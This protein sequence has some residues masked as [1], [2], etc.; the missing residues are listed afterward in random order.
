MI[1]VNTGS[2]TGRG[3]GSPRG[4]DHEDEPPGGRGGRAPAAAA[5]HRRHHRHRLHRHGVHAQPRPGAGACCARRSRSDRT[6]T[7]VVEISPLGLVEMTRQNVSE[8]VREIMNKTCPT[9][10]GE[11]VVRSEETI[12]IDVE[13]GL[14]KLAK[15]VEVGGVPGAGPPA[16]GGDPD[17][18]RRQAAARAGAGDRQASSTSRA[19]RASRSTRSGSPPRA[20]ATRSRSAR[21]RSSRA[22]RS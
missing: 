18:R 3:K 5:R 1:D 2:Y 16:R 10:D 22:R 9:C 20:R 15:D 4:H 12:A 14:R 7:H 17:R 11:G 19:P 13:R 6:R 21:C 8:G